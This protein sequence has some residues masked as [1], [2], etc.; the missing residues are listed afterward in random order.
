MSYRIHRVRDDDLEEL[1][2]LV[3]DYL[4]FYEV[5]AAERSR[6]RDPCAALLADPEREGVQ[7]LARDAAGGA[8][9][10][11][12]VYWTWVT[13]RLG[14][15]ATMNDHFVVPAHRGKGVAD[16]L[17]RGCVDV[18]R[19]GGAVRL[20]WHTAPDNVRAQKVYDRVGGERSQWLTYEIGC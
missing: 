11:A 16:A 15:S 18:A 20:Q 4:A 6:L 2:P 19:Q 14:R 13:T 1:L 17:I 3:Q 10:F 9:G 12:T 5:T 7:L 8:V